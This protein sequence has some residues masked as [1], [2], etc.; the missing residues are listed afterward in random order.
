MI[1]VHVYPYMYLN[2]WLLLYPPCSIWLGV[3][4]VKGLVRYT[5]Y[6]Y[7]DCHLEIFNSTQLIFS[8]QD[9]IDQTTYWT[10]DTAWWVSGIFTINGNFHSV[11]VQTQQSNQEFLKLVLWMP[12][13]HLQYQNNFQDKSQSLTVGYSILELESIWFM[14]WMS[15][16]QPTDYFPDISLYK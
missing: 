6:P 12:L 15:R 7:Y 1:N 8:T 13:Q 16:Q 10:L 9:L 5:R 3:L 4:P 2:L 11:P 14:L